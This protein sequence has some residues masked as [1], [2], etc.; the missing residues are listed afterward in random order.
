MNMTFRLYVLNPIRMKLG[1]E[2]NI[3]QKSTYIEFQADTSF[4]PISW[5]SENGSISTLQLF[6]PGEVQEYGKGR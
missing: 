5:T 6:L 4:R 3:W 2:N 1:V